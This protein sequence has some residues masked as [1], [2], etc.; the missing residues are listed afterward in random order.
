MAGCRQP[1]LN[2]SSLIIFAVIVRAYPFRW[3][4]ILE[5]R[6]VKTVRS[7]PTSARHESAAQAF[8]PIASSG[9]RELAGSDYHRLRRAGRSNAVRL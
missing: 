1:T 9:E 5:H 3:I 7:N 8:A 4:L 6:I 2:H